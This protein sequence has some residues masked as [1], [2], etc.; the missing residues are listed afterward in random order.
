MKR[1]LLLFFS[2]FLL[3]LNLIEAQ[4]KIIGS[5]ISAEDNEPV[6]GASVLIKGT[7]IGTIADL[8]GNFSLT[9]VPNSAKT[10]V[11][12]YIGMKTQ[13]VAIKPVLKIILESDTKALD[14]VVVSAMGI[15]RE[16]K[17]LGYALQEVKS[18]ELTK[19]GNSSLTSSLSGKIA[20]VQINQFGGTVGASSRISVRGNSSLNVDQQPLIVVD[21]VQI[22]RAHV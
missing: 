9:D 21:G 4:N 19:A 12:S 10:I 14:E 18:D 5:I 17:S 8:N 16:R 11:V 15:S 7:T 1:K 3:C 13:E 2:F 6:V 22:G 20:G